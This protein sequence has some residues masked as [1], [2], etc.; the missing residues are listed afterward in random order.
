MV[1]HYYLANCIFCCSLIFKMHCRWEYFLYL[2]LIAQ[3]I[4]TEYVEWH[5]FLE[6]TYRLEESEIQSFMNINLDIKFFWLE[7][8]YCCISNFFLS[9]NC[10]LVEITENFVGWRR[11]GKKL[12]KLWFCGFFFSK[13]SSYHAHLALFYRNIL[14]L[15]ERA[16]L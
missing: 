16:S 3:V 8:R 11:V 1:N 9:I 5:I 13:I 14:I 2:Q 12:G 4:F 10:V 6:P 7:K 15:N